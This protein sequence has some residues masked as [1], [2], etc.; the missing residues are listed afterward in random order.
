[1]IKMTSQ[2]DILK[3]IAAERNKLLSSTVTPPPPLTAEDIV[4]DMQEQ[5]NAGRGQQKVAGNKNMGAPKSPVSNE[6]T[7]DQV[8]DFWNIPGLK[9]KLQNDRR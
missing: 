8:K 9:K 4:R 7:A 1:V 5:A 6:I 2:E 3:A